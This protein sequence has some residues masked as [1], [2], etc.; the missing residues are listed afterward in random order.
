M[1]LENTC[2]ARPS[3]LGDIKCFFLPFNHSWQLCLAIFSSSVT[4][5]GRTD[6]LTFQWKYYFRFIQNFSK[7]VKLVRL[8]K[9]K[10]WIYANSK[11][12]LRACFC[13][14]KGQDKFDKTNNVRWLDVF[15]CSLVDILPNNFLRGQHILEL[16]VVYI[17]AWK[18]TML[19]G[20]H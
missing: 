7:L 9:K 5:F 1:T 20:T 8:L 4:F 17:H 12:F 14:Q 6:W 2:F 13:L 18:S 15:N 3:Y 10:F 16:W 11:T 19:H